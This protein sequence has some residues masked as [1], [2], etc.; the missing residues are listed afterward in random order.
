MIR[1]ALLWLGLTA[2]YLL[3]AGTLGATEIGASLVC[4]ALGALWSHQTGTR[5]LGPIRPPVSAALGRFGHALAGLPGETAAVARALARAARRGDLRGRVVPG[6]AAAVSR[7]SLADPAA[8]AAGERAVGTVAASLAP[9]TFVLRLDP[10]R[11]A[12]TLHVLD[13]EAA[14]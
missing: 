2:A 12:V 8:A 11:D 3:F 6:P 5:G 4:G 1:Y 10:T 9:R 13:P 7:F 14:P